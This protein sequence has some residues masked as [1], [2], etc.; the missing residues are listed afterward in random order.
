MQGRTITFR[1]EAREGAVS[2]ERG[3]FRETN[4][5]GGLEGGMEVPARAG[6]AAA[7]ADGG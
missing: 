4:R 3:Y 5:A 1:V 2:G 7:G 6:A